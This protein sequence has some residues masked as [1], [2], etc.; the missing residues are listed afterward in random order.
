MTCQHEL[1]SMSLFLCSP[2][3]W[4]ARRWWWPRRS[5]ATSARLWS[6][7]WRTSPLRETAFSK[8]QHI[9]QVQ[10]H[11]HYHCKYLMWSIFSVRSFHFTSCYLTYHWSCI[12]SVFL[13][14]THTTTF[15]WT[16]ELTFLHYPFKVKNICDS[17]CCRPNCTGIIAWYTHTVLFIKLLRLLL[18]ASGCCAT[19]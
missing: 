11:H 2:C 5:W 16:F 8:S 4:S 3:C 19:V 18:W 15:Q 7:T 9:S 12:E 13:G 1:T 10:H 17:P 14:Y 6:S